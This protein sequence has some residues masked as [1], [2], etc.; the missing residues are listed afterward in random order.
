MKKLVLAL[1][2]FLV[3][4]ILLAGCK[5][6]P[7]GYTAREGFLHPGVLHTQEDLETLRAL[8]DRWDGITRVTNPDGTVTVTTDLASAVVPST[9]Q[10]DPAATANPATASGQ[11]FN[12]NESVVEP[13]RWAAW[14]ELKA[15]N[16]RG[17]AEY[18]AYT[19]WNSLKA[20]GNAAHTYAVKGPYVYLAR[21]G[22][23]GGNKTNIETD[24]RA[25]YLNALMWMLTGDKRHAMKSFEIMDGYARTA[26]GILDGGTGDYRLMTGLQGSVFACAAELIRYGKDTVNHED[27]GLT[28]RQF[29]NIENSMRNVWIPCMDRF[30]GNSPDTQGNVGLCVTS[31]YLGMAIFLDDE[32]MYIKAL[33]FWLNGFDN[34]NLANYVH[35]VSGQNQETKR[36]QGHAVLGLMKL[37][38]V[39]EMFY[40][41]GD[42]VY[43][44]FDNSLW[45]GSEFSAR[46]NMGDNNFTN[47]PR[48]FDPYSEWYYFD[49]LWDD[50]SGHNPEVIYGDL[51]NSFEPGTGSRGSTKPAFEILYN[52]YHRRQGMPM[53]W[54]EAYLPRDGEGYDTADSPPAYASFLVAG[55]DVFRELGL[56]P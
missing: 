28:D 27:S 22:T 17:Y 29:V 10:A 16:R 3:T 33:N 35:P 40:K 5:M 39:C 53:P 52:H 24:F 12:L 26:R 6:S 32:E 4:G 20:D 46:Y 56:A 31:A 38:V 47:T 21:D 2:G 50:V 25:A 37:G 7:T 54:T 9:P 19:S 1:T 14:R 44:A 55:P 43:S 8:I 45:K 18:R 41:Q 49:A 15:A 48:E 51:I 23:Y 30:Y 42:N 13:E 11:D 36:D 34:G